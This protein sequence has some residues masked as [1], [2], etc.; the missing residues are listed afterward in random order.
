MWRKMIPESLNWYTN[1]DWSYWLKIWAR[2]KKIP[3]VITARELKVQKTTEMDLNVCQILPASYVLPRTVSLICPF[4]EGHSAGPQPY[5]ITSQNYSCMR[6]STIFTIFMAC[7]WTLSSMFLPLLHWEVQN[8]T[9]SSRC[10]LT[11]A[12]LRRRIIF[13]EW[14][15]ALLLMQSTRPWAFLLQVCTA[16]VCSM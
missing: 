9:E 2:E 8:W 6:F 15:A 5:V 13:L 3:Q 1:R 14:L 10:G 4:F 11:R 12:E 16:G 7:F